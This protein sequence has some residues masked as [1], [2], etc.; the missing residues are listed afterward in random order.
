MDPYCGPRTPLG[1]FLVEDSSD[2]LEALKTLVSEMEGAS[3]IGYASTVREALERIPAC[4]PDV[5]LLDIHLPDGTGLDILRDLRR[6]NGQTLPVVI[7]LSTE[8]D[9]RYRQAFHSMGASFYFDK[10]LEFEQLTEIFRSLA[11]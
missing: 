10:A 4:K 1:V 8:T 11:G 9:P 2:V 5:V 3:L 7:V 6:Q